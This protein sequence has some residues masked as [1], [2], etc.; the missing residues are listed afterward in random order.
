M[1]WGEL[2]PAPDLDVAALW[3]GRGI[4]YLPS[5]VKARVHLAEIYASRRQ[6]SDAEALLPTLSSADSEAGWRL[7]DVLI[8]RSEI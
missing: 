5:Y 4:A 3:Y 6:T 2:V 1:L 8:A 7:A